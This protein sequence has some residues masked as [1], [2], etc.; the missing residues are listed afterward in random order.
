MSARPWTEWERRRC[1]E[2]VREGRSGG[3]IAQTLERSKL[4]VWGMLKRLG[5]RVQDPKRVFTCTDLERAQ[6]LRASGA[7]Y[8]QIAAEMG[9]SDTTVRENLV[10]AGEPRTFRKRPWSRAELAGAVALRNEGL[11]YRQIAART[12]RHPSDLCK[13]IREAQSKAAKP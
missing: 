3:E 10:A 8:A 7:T 11:S 6:G 13:R 1:I 5:I 9:H 12:G 4:S 2:M